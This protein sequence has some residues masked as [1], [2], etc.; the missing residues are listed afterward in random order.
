[1]INFFF[2]IIPGCFL[3]SRK[4]GRIKIKKGYCINAENNF[5]DRVEVFFKMTREGFIPSLA[6]SK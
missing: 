5:E 1:V 4:E 6:E 3:I 2:G